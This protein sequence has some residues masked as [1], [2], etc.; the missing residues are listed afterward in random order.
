MTNK[1]ITLIEILVVV[2]LFGMILFFG[3]IVDLHSYRGSIFRSERMVLISHLT[4]ARNQS[5]NN[6]NEIKHGLCYDNTDPLNPK[7]VLFEGNTFAS[8]LVKENL[9]A[10]PNVSITPPTSIF[11]CSVG[12]GIVFDQLSGKSV[13]TSITVTQDGRTSNI[14]I[15]N[16]GTINW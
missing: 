5:M 10:D 16:E 1:G 6:M 14:S 13:D 9:K 4:K 7:Y 11:F 2:A 3:L 8:A 15:N 12:P